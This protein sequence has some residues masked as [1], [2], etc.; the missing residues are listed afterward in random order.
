MADQARKT[1]QLRFDMQK[2]ASAIWHL[3]DSH[4]ITRE[5]R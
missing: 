2:N 1:F 5:A 4:S 3:F